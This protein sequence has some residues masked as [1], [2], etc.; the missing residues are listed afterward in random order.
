LARLEKKMLESMLVQEMAIESTD[1]NK[2]MLNLL[3]G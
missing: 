3:S 1:E 2:L